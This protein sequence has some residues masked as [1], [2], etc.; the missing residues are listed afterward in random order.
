MALIAGV[1]LLRVL[2]QQYVQ[3]LL[4]MAETLR[5]ML[6]ANRNFRVIP[7]ARPRCANWRAPP[8]TWRSSATP[9]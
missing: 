8:T 9:C 1:Q 3:G 6:G 7:T 4:R 5:L 2:F